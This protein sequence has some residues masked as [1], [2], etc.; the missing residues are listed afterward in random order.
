[1]LSFVVEAFRAAAEAV[2]Q[3]NRDHQLQAHDLGMRLAQQM[4]QQ[5]QIAGQGEWT[6]G[7]GETLNLRCESGLINPT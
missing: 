1:L 6:C 5:R 4:L 7:H 3:Q 2:A